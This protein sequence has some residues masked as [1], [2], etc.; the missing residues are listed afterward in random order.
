[1]QLD[2]ALHHRLVSIDLDDLRRTPN[3]VAVASG[4]DKAE[5]VSSAIRG[6]LVHTLVADAALS[7][8]LLAVLTPAGGR[9]D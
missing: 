7:T 9:P 2:L 6:G 8:A 1:M 3:V 5:A 4:A